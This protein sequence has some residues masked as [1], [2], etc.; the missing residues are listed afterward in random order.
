MNQCRAQPTKY[1]N[2]RMRNSV[3]KWP[4]TKSWSFYYHHGTAQKVQLSRHQISASPHAN[5]AKCQE[6][7]FGRSPQDAALPL[8]TRKKITVITETTA[9]RPSPTVSLGQPPPPSLAFSGQPAARRLVPSIR[10]EVGV[11]SNPLM[12]QWR[13]RTP[14]SMPSSGH[15]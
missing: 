8:N 5:I 6:D 12:G 15:A 14:S 13:L 11:V 2:V 7:I 1:A 10:L 4:P 9:H 3:P